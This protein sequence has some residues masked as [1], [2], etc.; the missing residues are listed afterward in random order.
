MSLGNAG[1]SG[2]RQLA[3]PARLPPALQFITKGGGEDGTGHVPTLRAKQR[4]NHDVSGNRS[5]DPSA[6][7][8]AGLFQVV[9]QIVDILDPDG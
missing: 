1:L 6:E 4:R 8:G 2:Q 7:V 9:D 3:H 5:W